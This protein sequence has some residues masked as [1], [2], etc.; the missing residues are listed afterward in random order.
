MLLRVEG[1]TVRG[2]ASYQRQQTAPQE[3]EE[4]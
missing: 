4:Y 2:K 1:R 3:Q